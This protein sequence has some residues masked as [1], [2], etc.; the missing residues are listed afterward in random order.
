MK[1]NKAVEGVVMSVQAP[2]GSEITSFGGPER[3]SSAHVGACAVRD[4]SDRVE[5]QAGGDGYL[6]GVVV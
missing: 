2:A 3:V 5:I 1:L 4:P 6:Q